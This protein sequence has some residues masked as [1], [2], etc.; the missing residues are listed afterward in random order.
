MRKWLPRL[1]VCRERELF[2]KDRI[3]VMIVI[4]IKNSLRSCKN[5]ALCREYTGQMQR[6]AYHKIFSKKFYK[7]AKKH[8]QCRK[9]YAII[10]LGCERLVQ[11]IGK[12]P[13]QATIC[14]D[15]G[16]CRVRNSDRRV[17]P[18]SMSDLRTGRNNY[19][20][21]GICTGMLCALRPISRYIVMSCPGRTARSGSPAFLV[22]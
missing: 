1:P 13:A 6:S 10:F 18:R 17:F 7:N 19:E 15:A 12:Q 4:S 16:G 21:D 20:C 22:R 8:L 3:A 11:I 2:C 9:S 14:V 5:C